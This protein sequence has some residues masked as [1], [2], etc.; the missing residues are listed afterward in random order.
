MEEKLK[1]R[2]VA[3]LRSGKYQQ[4]KES[5]RGEAFIKRDDDDYPLPEYA[6]IEGATGYCCLGVL[7]ELL[8]G[9]KWD[10]GNYTIT[11]QTL[12]S[13][14]AAIKEGESD[15]YAWSDYDDDGYPS[16]DASVFITT[17]QLPPELVKHFGLHKKVTHQG[18]SRDVQQ[19]LISLNDD[20]DAGKTFNKIADYIEKVL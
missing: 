1:A 19:K 15:E 14:F 16:K 9:V 3:A 11:N 18:R 2:W 7:C 20:Y 8:P 6:D 12:K 4:A 13:K 17:E 10:S 5:L